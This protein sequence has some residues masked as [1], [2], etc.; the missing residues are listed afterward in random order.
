MIRV[1][2]VVTCPACNRRERLNPKAGETYAKLF[3]A[4]VIAH[5]QGVCAHFGYGAWNFNPD[6]DDAPKPSTIYGA[7]VKLR[8]HPDGYMF[9][10]PAEWD[11]L[12]IANYIEQTRQKKQR[13]VEE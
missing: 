4:I 13:K 7:K 8:H 11:E 1:E 3:R 9:T 5:E 10:T 12:R 6:W 2:R